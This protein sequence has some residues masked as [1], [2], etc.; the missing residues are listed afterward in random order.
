MKKRTLS[1]PG[2]PKFKD[3]KERLSVEVTEKTDKDVQKLVAK[4]L[5]IYSIIGIIGGF[6]FM[7]IAVWILVTK[8]TVIQNP[9]IDTPIIKLS[10]SQLTISIVFAIIGLLIIWITVFRFKIK[11]G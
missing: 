10:A 8:D 2:F 4:Y 9:I 6:I 7:G 11:N 1:N 5:F 3:I